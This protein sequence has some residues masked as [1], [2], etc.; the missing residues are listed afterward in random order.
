MV[1]SLRGADVQA[2]RGGV[3]GLAQQGADARQRFGL[4]GFVQRDL[5]VHGA[6][7]VAFEGRARFV[8][9]V[10]AL[11][12]AAQVRAEDAGRAHGQ[13]VLVGDRIGLHQAAGQQRIDIQVGGRRVG[14]AQAVVGQRV[15]EEGQLG[16]QRVQIVGEFGE[17]LGQPVFVALAGRLF[18]GAGKQRVIARRPLRV[19]RCRA[20]RLRRSAR[21]GCRR[22][23]RPG[24]G[25]VPPA[26]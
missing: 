12:C 7:Q 20:A 21:Y 19:T 22:C 26:P 11:L 1:G 3:F 17:D 15:A 4:G 10:V 5:V 18:A 9:R 8:G 2:G 25:P 14:V 23:P 6:A 13:E 24:S 16:A